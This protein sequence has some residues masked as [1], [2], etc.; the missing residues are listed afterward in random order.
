MTNPP[1]TGRGEHEIRRPG[2][3]KSS[4]E[5]RN[6]DLALLSQREQ[7]TPFLRFVIST[8]IYPHPALENRP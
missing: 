6:L 4:S 7:P 1:E 8:A 2:S 5:T 3:K